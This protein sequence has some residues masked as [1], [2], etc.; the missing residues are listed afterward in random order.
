MS[1]SQESI[2]KA[3]DLLGIVDANTELE[4]GKMK[5]DESKMAEAD[6]EDDAEVISEEADFKGK[7]PSMEKGYKKGGT[8]GNTE[9]QM[10]EEGAIRD[11]EDH[12]AALKEDKKK[13]EEKLAKLKEDAKTE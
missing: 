8:E 3:F 6:K 2:N 4:K 13:D 1:I 5:K 11:D 7:K 12:E 10:H 9:E